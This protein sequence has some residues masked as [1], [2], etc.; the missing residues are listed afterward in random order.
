M[1]SWLKMHSESQQMDSFNIAY[2]ASAQCVS[3]LYKLNAF[4]IEIKE[5]WV[6]FHKRLVSHIMERLF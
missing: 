2:V 1:E 5:S 3:E 4:V 6:I